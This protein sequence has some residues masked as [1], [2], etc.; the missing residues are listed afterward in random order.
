[1]SLVAAPPNPE[2][3][4]CPTCRAEQPWQD[5]CRRCKSDLGFLREVAN[6]YFLARSTCLSNL[7]DGRL[8]EAEEAA[9][10]CHELCPSEESQRLRGC[11]ALLKGDYATAASVILDKA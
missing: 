3:L 7:R 2:T 5:T 6:A 4:R 1:M 9:R 8:L 10:R 11:V